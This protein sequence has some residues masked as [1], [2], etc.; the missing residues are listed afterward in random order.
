MAATLLISDAH[1]GSRVGHAV[2]QR[3]AEL[4]GLLTA[5][6][7]VGHLVILGDLLELNEGRPPRE[8]LDLAAPTLRGIA[9]AGLERIT[10]LPGNHDRRLI[11]PWISAQ[12][13]D[14]RLQ[15][16]VPPDAT[17][18]LAE[19][20]D[21]L[22]GGGAE[23]QVVYPG[24]SLGE[25]IWVTHGHYLDRAIAPQGPYGFLARP[26]PTTPSAHERPRTPSR[27]HRVGGRWIQERILRPELAPFT[28]AGL[29]WQ[30]RRHSLPA[31]ARVLG[32]LGVEAD[33]VVFG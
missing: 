8:V 22:S 21:Q 12:G 6:E 17:P 25:R 30:M 3:P 15:A 9:E 32:A 16:T 10:L 5:L 2:L 4:A 7:P 14:L 1:L 23:V 24:L 33:Y 18:L 28:A 29:D 26:A 27:R 19:V 31:L 11:S 13:A 20:V